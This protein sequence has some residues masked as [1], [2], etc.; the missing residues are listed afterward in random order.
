MKSNNQN[1]GEKEEITLKK[2]HP[3]FA[4]ISYFSYKFNTIKY[5]ISLSLSP[6]YLHAH[7]RDI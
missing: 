4:V 7:S 6:L 3:F 5:T 1:N 2:I